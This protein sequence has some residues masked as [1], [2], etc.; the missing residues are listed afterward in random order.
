MALTSFRATGM[1]S[2]AA[3]VTTT[4]SAMP[5]SVHVRTSTGE[6]V[7]TCTHAAISSLC[8][9][10]ESLALPMLGY[11]DPYDDTWFN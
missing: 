8:R 9:R 10:A 11:V 1:M 7:T 3:S 4:V 5:I 6:T 2:P